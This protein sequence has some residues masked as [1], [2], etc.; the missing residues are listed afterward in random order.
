MAAFLK[1]LDEL[2]PAFNYRVYKTHTQKEKNNLQNIME[3]QIG[4][5]QL[6]EGRGNC[7][8]PQEGVR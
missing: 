7:H 3:K 4:S 2:F 1:V 5:Q 6:L 8:F